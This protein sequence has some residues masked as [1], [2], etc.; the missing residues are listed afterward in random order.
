MTSYFTLCYSLVFSPAIVIFL[1]S[2][3]LKGGHKLYVLIYVI[4]II[5]TGTSSSLIKNLI[6]KLKLQFALKE[7]GE[8]DN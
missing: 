6:T 8:L 2:L 1:C 7:L 5:I 3:T 4:D